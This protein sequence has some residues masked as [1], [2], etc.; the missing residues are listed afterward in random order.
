[1]LVERKWI[2]K[3]ITEA[4]IVQKVQR[5]NSA[6]DEFKEQTNLDYIQKEK[7]TDNPVLNVE[8]KMCT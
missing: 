7:S 3:Q 5:E 2:M 6:R 8:N 4:W 1:M